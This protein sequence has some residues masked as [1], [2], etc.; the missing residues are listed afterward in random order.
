MIL[1]IFIYE[2]S[3]ALRFIMDKNFYPKSWKTSSWVGMD[4]TDQED[5]TKHQITANTYVGVRL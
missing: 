5:Y 2:N 1:I 4:C 3:G